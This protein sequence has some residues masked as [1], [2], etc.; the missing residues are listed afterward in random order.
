MPENKVSLDLE[1][2]EELLNAKSK[3][4]FVRKIIFNKKNTLSYNK[5]DISFSI[6]ALCVKLIFPEE[7][8]DQIKILSGGEE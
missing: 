8:A 4:N 3:L 5:E 1:V 7:Y 2:Y 6:D